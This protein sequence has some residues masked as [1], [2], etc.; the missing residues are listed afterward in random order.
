MI[1]T[2]CLIHNCF[3]IGQD[4]GFNYWSL[5]WPV[6]GNGLVQIENPYNLSSWTNA[7]PGITTQSHGWWLMPAY[8]AMKH[9]SY[10]IQP[11]YKRVDATDNDNNI[12]TSAFLS[13][14][15][16]RLVVVSINTNASV[17]SAMNFNFGTFNA[18]KTNVYQT[19]GTNTFRLLGTLTNSQ[20]LPP[21]SITTVVLDQLVNVGAATNPLPANNATSI[22]LNSTLSWTPGSNAL[23]HAVYLGINSNF[24]AAAAAGSP[25]FQGVLT[26]TNF[27]PSLVSGLTYFWRVDEMA[28][29]NTNFGAIWSF[30]TVAPSASFSL[31]AGDALNATSF[32]AIGNWVTNGTSSPATAPPN[33]IGAYNTR[34]FTLRTPTTGDATFGGASLTLS[35]GAPVDKG[36]LLLKGPNGAMVTINNLILSGGIIG[37]G[38]NSGVGGILSVAGNIS[39]VSN[40]VVSGTGTTARYIGMAANLTGSASI[41]NDCNVIY[42]GNNSGFTGQLIV[43]SGG[44]VQFGDSINLGGSGA[45]LV[46]NNGT[47][48]PTA[49]FALNNFGGNATLNSGG[50]IFQI[51]TNLTLTI[52]NPIVGVGNLLCI[53]GGTLQIA[54]SNSATGNLIVSNVTLAL[55]GDATFKNSQ[56]GVSNNATMNVTALNVPLSVSNRGTLTL[57]NFGPSLA[58]GDT[59]KLFSAS[60]YSGAFSGIIP[61]A[62]GTG[63]Q[64]N[65]NWLS[66]DGTIFVTSTNP[67]LIMPPKI[68]SFQFAGT[69]W[70]VNGTNGNAPGTFFYTLA[71]TNLTLPLTNWTVIATNQFSAGGGFNFTNT[72]DSSKFEQFFIIQIP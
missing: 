45:K 28:G 16:L 13:P 14:D 55:L 22:A 23:T 39:V 6:G 7:P 46:L 64:W 10:F 52:S 24:V 53:G 20:I 57:S 5:V 40:S 69:K 56:F 68:V 36:S 18:G 47:F 11:G 26:T 21:L 70:I 35:A 3:T 1:Q 58:Y 32:N 65:T 31:N 49:S 29:A 25:E 43:G 67:A 9:F 38:V 27:N 62:P 60:N 37:H 30:S 33:S 51:V 66:A 2:A 61:V 4:S 48:Q 19:V 8:W 12:R 41:S 50:G 72:F 15:N 63:L 54:G 44:N 42:S 34:A 17:S 71:S 59:I